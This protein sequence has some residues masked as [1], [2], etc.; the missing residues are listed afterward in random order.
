MVKFN[1]LR[2]LDAARRIEEARDLHGDLVEY[3]ADGNDT[4]LVARQIADE[5]RVIRDALSV[6]R[7]ERS[8]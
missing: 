2:E 1:S 6:I 5:Q 4:A 3:R 7:E 8:C